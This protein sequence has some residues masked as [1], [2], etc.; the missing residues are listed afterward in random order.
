MSDF[1]QTW[2]VTWEVQKTIKGALSCIIENTGRTFKSGR[3]VIEAVFYDGSRQEICRR[4][5]MTLTS[6]KGQDYSVCR[7]TC[8]EAVKPA[9]RATARATAEE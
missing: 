6:K 8:A 7:R 1:N 5:G 9:A 4:E 2:G 3:A